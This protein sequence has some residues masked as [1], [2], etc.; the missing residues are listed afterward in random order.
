MP[1]AESSSGPA[2]CRAI[3]DAGSLGGY[4][5]TP[6]AAG[7][8]TDFRAFRLRHISALPGKRAIIRVPGESFCRIPARFPS[9]NRLIP[10]GSR[11]NSS[12]GENRSI[13]DYNRRARPWMRALRCRPSGPIRCAPRIAASRTSARCRRVHRCSRSV[14][15]PK[16]SRSH[17]RCYQPAGR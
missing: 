5:S 6:S 3:S 11:L 2:P 17:S 7:Q 16:R 8:N 12:M 9:G 13:C 1:P 10:P 15:I 14:R 4:G